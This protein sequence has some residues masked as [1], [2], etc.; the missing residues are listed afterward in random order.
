M[1]ANVSFEIVINIFPNIT[2]LFLKE[3]TFNLKECYKFIN[4]IQQTTNLQN[5]LRLQRVFYS[6]K[7]Q[8][9]DKDISKVKLRLKEI[10]WNFIK[11]QQ[12]IIKMTRKNMKK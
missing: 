4:F 8:I 1:E 5:D 9:K 11:S 6:M 2:D 3:T 7:K 10:G 12:M